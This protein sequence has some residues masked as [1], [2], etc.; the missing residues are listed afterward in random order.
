MV[1]SEHHE[2]INF[3]LV[4]HGGSGTYSGLTEA[5]T[6]TYKKG[7]DT[8]LEAGYRILEKGGTSLDAVTAAVTI[9]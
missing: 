6:K 2:T 4:V 9:L 3:G 8:A 1:Y 7:I 5:S